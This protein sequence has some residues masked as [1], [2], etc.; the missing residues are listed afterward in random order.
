MRC[1]PTA[2]TIIFILQFP[3]SM[4]I[5]KNS[6]FNAKDTW[7]MHR[8]VEAHPRRLLHLYP[9]SSTFQWNHKPYVIIWSLNNLFFAMLIK[10]IPM[11]DVSYLQFISNSYSSI[12]HLISNTSKTTINNT[13]NSLSLPSPFIPN[14]IPT[15]THATF[16]TYPLKRERERESAASEYS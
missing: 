7:R 11:W 8:I 13:N 1:T 10:K 15:W 12:H 14:D 6:T 2:I 5:S 3:I 9:C 4:K 16:K